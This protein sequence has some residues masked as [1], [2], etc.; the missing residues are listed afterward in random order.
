[1]SKAPTVRHDYLPAQRT[2][3]KWPVLARRATTLLLLT[4]GT[5][6]VAQVA[7]RLWAH[8][9]PAT[10]L[11][12]PAP[13]SGFQ[14]VALPLPANTAAP[15][16]GTNGTGPAA[17]DRAPART[18]LHRHEL[19]VRAGD[20]LA[21]IFSR[22]HLPPATLHHIMQLG[23]PVRALRALHPGDRLRFE[24]DDQGRLVRLTHM[25]DR[26]HRLVVTWDEGGFQARNQVR[27]ADRT[28]HLA[29]ATIDQSLF[30]AGHRA[31][32]S[33]R[34]IM[35]LAGIFGWDIDFALDIRRGDR[36]AVL[37][38]DLHLD[39]ERIG[40]GHIV[41]AEFTNQGHTYRAIRYTDPSGRTDYYSPEGRS[42]RR[43]FLRTPVAFTRISSRFSLGRWHPIL[44][45]M[46]AHKGVDYAAPIGT[47]VK[48]T[49]DGKVIWRGRKGGYGNTLILRHGSRYTTVYAHLSR[50]ARGIH[51]GSHVRQGQVIAY[52]GMTGLATGPHLHYEFRIDGVHHNPLTVKLPQAR[53]LPRRYRADFR[54]HARALLAKL[55]LMRRSPTRLAATE[56]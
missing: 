6:A 38:E 45:R 20:S 12:R 52:V 39:G 14:V 50:F 10:A 41:A 28:L 32:L 17:T 2:A 26:F 37:Y 44:H 54:R 55:D 56:E 13:G 9:R 40:S 23:R 5:L 49:G 22:L 46:R 4:A 15:T 19:R 35:E 29:S 11:A 34:L 30:L 16:A 7:R 8:P 43:A 31:G 3:A 27:T 48:A 51:T 42:L 21:R 25:P 1:M 18:P 36:F 24:T 53:P 33:D 47:P